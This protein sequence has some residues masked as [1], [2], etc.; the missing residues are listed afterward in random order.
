MS[1]DYYYLQKTK[2][3]FEER[4]YLV[5]KSEKTYRVYKEEEDR[6]IFVKAD[7]FCSDLIAMSNE[8]VCFVQVKANKGDISKAIKKYKKLKRP[9]CRCVK[10]LVVAWEPRKK[11]PFIIDIDD[12]GEIRWKSR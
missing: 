9:K 1:K 6:V 5:E 2:K 11:E 7:M 4:G 10:F 12:V 3:Y 8:N